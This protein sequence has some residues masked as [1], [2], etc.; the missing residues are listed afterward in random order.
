MSSD[1]ASL[2]WADA[3]I[4]PGANIDILLILFRFSFKSTFKRRFKSSRFVDAVPRDAGI[5]L[6]PCD[7]TKLIARLEK[8]S[9]TCSACMDY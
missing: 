3:E 7:R 2:P 6:P 9:K 4:F 8:R 5:Y 1:L